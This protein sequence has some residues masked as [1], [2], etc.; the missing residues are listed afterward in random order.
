M[1][2]YLS[3]Q[4]LLSHKYR[5]F[6]LILPQASYAAIPQGRK[7]AIK[8]QAPIWGPTSCNQTMT[9]GG[10]ASDWAPDL[11]CCES[12]NWLISNSSSAGKFST[13]READSFNSWR[14]QCRSRRFPVLPCYGIQMICRFNNTVFEHSRS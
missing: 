1:P 3:S 10:F 14:H 11:G 5:P 8:S 13:Y 6:F 2:L 7:T 12:Y 9:L 4:A